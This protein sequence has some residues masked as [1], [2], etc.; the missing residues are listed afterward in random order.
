MHFALPLP[1]LLTSQ[2]YGKDTL[3]AVTIKQLNEAQQ[4]YPDAEFRIDNAEITQVTFVGQI[5]NIST[6]ATNH[7]FRL[8]DGTGNIEVKQWIDPDSRTEG[9][10]TKIS[11]LVENAYARVWG[12]LK[13]F[14]EKRHVGAQVIRPI[15][16]HNEVQGHLLEATVQHLIFTRGPVG[17]G[18]G[19]GQGQGGQ[20][21]GGGENGH[22]GGKTL[23]AGMS[24]GAR[25][26]YAC[27]QGAE[28]TNEGLHMQD[29]A[30]RL[31]MELAD[32]GKAGDELLTQGLIYTT[33]D[34]ETW[35]VLDEI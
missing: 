8:D 24:V 20:A 2:G 13:V 33:L 16:D 22:A 9:Q 14:S 30:S 25:K 12:R 3:R 28:Q 10:D 26:I 17:G 19:Q 29:I 4:P 5:R 7:T 27:I 21:N 32:V 18:E 1:F 6:Q 35:A 23:P 31:G 11:G 34:D 15:T